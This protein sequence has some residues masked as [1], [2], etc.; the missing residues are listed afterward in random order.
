MKKK[1]YITPQTESYLFAIENLMLTASPGISDE[2]FDP[3]HDE[4]GAKKNPGFWGSDYP[5]YSPWDD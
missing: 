5:R 1:Q 4:V 3:D 2:E